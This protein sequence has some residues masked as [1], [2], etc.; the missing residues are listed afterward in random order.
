VLLT[1]KDGQT[2]CLC[3]W[4]AS[5]QEFVYSSLF[6]YSIIYIGMNSW[7]FI[8]LFIHSFIFV[9]LGF[10]IRAYTLSHFTSPFL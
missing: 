10:E 9:V 4:N 6:I 5:A 7:V 3:I 1:L 8:Y 2:I